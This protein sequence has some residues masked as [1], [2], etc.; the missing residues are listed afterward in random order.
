MLLE[1]FK[2][3][4]SLLQSAVSIISQVKNLLPKDTKSQE[5]HS[6]LTD[7]ETNLKLSEVAFAKEIGYQLCK[8]TW[9][10]QIML[11]IGEVDYGEKYKCPSC[12]KI[13]SDDDM[14]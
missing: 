3:G 11:S 4:I 7:A 14:P 12:N 10:P 5:L 8:C 13:I 6:K 2:E 1:P 9:P